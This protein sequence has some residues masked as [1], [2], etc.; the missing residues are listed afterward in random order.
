MLN[1]SAMSSTT[2]GP[3]SG[4]NSACADRPLPGGAWL[5]G[6]RQA[7][8]KL[9]LR[10]GPAPAGHVP[11]RSPG[12]RALAGATTVVPVF[13]PVRRPWPLVAAAPRRPPAGP[14]RRGSPGL[15]RC[16]SSARKASAE[17]IGR[18]CSRKRSR[19]SSKRPRHAQ[20]DDCDGPLGGAGGYQ[21]ALPPRF[22]SDF[23]APGRRARLRGLLGRR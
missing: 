22:G 19:M 20:F 3:A 5:S 6:R 9:R 23:L 11:S 16:P 18:S 2:W 15:S 4:S 12:S 17:T 21:G 13:Q 1:H 7:R 8:W 10:W 14:G